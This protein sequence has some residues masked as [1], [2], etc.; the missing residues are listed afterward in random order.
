MW[1]FQNTQRTSTMGHAWK[2]LWTGFYPLCWETVPRLEQKLITLYDRWPQVRVILIR[3]CQKHGLWSCQI[4]FRMTVTLKQTFLK[5][6]KKITRFSYNF[7]HIISMQ[8]LKI[9][10]AL[11]HHITVLF[12]IKY[13][14]K[15]NIIYYLCF[16]NDSVWIADVLRQWMRH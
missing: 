1:M 9:C 3:V 6:M 2:H 10:P 7:Q 13:S 4:P 5:H 14:E 8:K 11:P 12:F 16:E 15:Q